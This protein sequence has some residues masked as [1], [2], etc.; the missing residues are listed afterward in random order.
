MWPFGHVTLRT[1]ELSP[2][3]HH[4]NKNTEH[5]TNTLLN[6]CNCKSGR[7]LTISIHHHHQLLMTNDYIIPV[8]AGTNFHS[9]YSSAD[10]NEF[11]SNNKRTVPVHIIQLKFG[12]LVGVHHRTIVQ[13]HQRATAVSHDTAVVCV[14]DNKGRAIPQ[15]SVFLK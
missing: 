15:F 13:V 14:T 7:T 9:V 1:S 3:C 2:N 11:N 6:V 8:A 5:I 4:D 10:K 12:N